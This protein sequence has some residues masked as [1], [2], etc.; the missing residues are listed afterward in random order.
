M[1]VKVT[2][3]VSDGFLNTSNLSLSRKYTRIKKRS[4]QSASYYRI[5]SIP[6]LQLNK[7][8]QTQQTTPRKFN[9]KLAQREQNG[10]TSSIFLVFVNYPHIA[11]N[12]HL[13]FSM[14][15]QFSLARHHC[16]ARFVFSIFFFFFFFFIS[17]FFF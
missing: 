1:L 15:F 3:K 16:L 14:L 11:L 9:S 4:C 10:N 6:L 13:L 5:I 12:L 7:P 8:T 17:F 2:V